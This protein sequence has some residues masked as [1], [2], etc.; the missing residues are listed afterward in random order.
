M[1]SKAEQAVEATVEGSRETAL[2]LAEV[3]A[4]KGAGDIVLLEIGALVS[5]TDYLLL[6]TA[7]NE[8]MVSAI[9]DEARLRLKHDSGRLPRGADG[10]ADTG[11]RVMDYLDCVLHIFTAEARDRFQ[12]DELWREAPREELSDAGPGVD[13]GSDSA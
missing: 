5:Y 7:R 1:T 10:D 9:A 11:W 13:P 2:R 4:S 3:A 12:L 6:C 8:R